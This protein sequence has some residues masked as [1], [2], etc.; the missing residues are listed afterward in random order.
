MC[1][2]ANFLWSNIFWGNT[3][4][5]GQQLVR[6]RNNKNNCSNYLE[7]PVNS[8]E[9][10]TNKCLQSLYNLHESIKFLL[11]E[12]YEAGWDFS[13]APGQQQQ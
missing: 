8:V 11:C 13:I 10:S 5:I 2:V 3:F 4:F 6:T 1:L 9:A 7:N 12:A